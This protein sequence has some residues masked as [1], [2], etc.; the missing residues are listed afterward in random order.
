LDWFPL[1]VS[2]DFIDGTIAII[3][4]I[5]GLGFV[6]FVHELG[7]FVV[8]KLC[9]VKCE[10]FYL[11]FDIPFGRFINW[12]IGRDGELRLFGLGIPRTIGPPVRW[13]E[14]QYGIGIIPLGGY[15]KMLGQEDNPAQFREEMERARQR[16][17]AAQAPAEQPGTDGA[18]RPSAQAEAASAGAAPGNGSPRANAEGESAATPD[19]PLFD[20]RSFL[21]KSVPQ[22]MAIISAGV[23][24][25]L[26]FAFV[27]AVIAFGLGV[28][29]IASGVGG[30]LPG[31]AAWQVGLRVGDQIV[32]V[33]GQRIKKFRDM[34]E[35]IS[36]GDKNNEGQQI[37]VRRPGREELLTFAVKPDDTGLIPMIGIVNPHTNTLAE[38]PVMPGSA[39]ARA[40]PE[41]RAGD[42]IVEMADEPIDTYVDVHSQLALNYGQPLSI[43]VERTVGDGNG[44]AS[45]GPPKVE[46][47]AVRVPIQPMRRV[48]LE[49]E[50]GEIVAVQDGSP[51]AVAGIRPGDVIR[52]IDFHPAAGPDATDE[53]QPAGDP[54][55]LP[56][57]LRARAGKPVQI[58]VKR[59][60]HEELLPM[61][62]TLRV[63][64]WYETP[65]A[66]GSPVSVPVLGVAYVV[67][68]RVHAPVKGSPAAKA[69]MAAGDVVVR[70]RVIPPP[71]EP[72]RKQPFQQKEAKLE[73]DEKNRNWPSFLSALQETL[74][75][76]T[77]EL[78]WKDREGKQQSGTLVPYAAADWFNP[79]RGFVFKPK[80]ILQKAKSLGE[81]I[82]LGWEE[83]VR[84]TLL[85]YRFIQK[86][87]TRRVSPKALG[88]PVSIFIVA[89]REA[90][91]GTARLLIFLTLL[92]ANLAV[93]NFL[94]IPM[95]DG[96]HMVLLAYEGIRGKPADERVQGLLNWIGL[97]FILTLMIWVL[98]LDFGWIPRQ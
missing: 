95:L 23:I 27:M 18:D 60:G 87:S 77:V 30:V 90:E 92:S 17:E 56:Q 48:G 57:R 62:V 16:A 42:T 32:E 64:D 70:V 43:V 33:D 22:R 76:T 98:G 75:G 67:L 51:A 78:T 1:A 55:T 69:G 6:I 85:V 4:V 24:M 54:I 66:D 65:I 74:P 3:K 61:D 36:L 37:T 2:Q 58:F 91:Q 59:E 28:Q 14:T 96:G 84:S 97:M 63:A 38:V 53:P 44:D 45:Q 82:A 47:L 80:L 26:I 12:L 73:F 29:Q 83:T 72:G 19:S 20:P 40:T 79:E 52:Q 25:N 81:A 94:P 8:A 93:I 9:G 15:V 46:H 50:M 86:L 49:M 21:A 41:L 34:Q 39:A 35:A 5:A 88:G 89:K 31:E 7:H 13:G 68:N 11:G 10:K 71:G